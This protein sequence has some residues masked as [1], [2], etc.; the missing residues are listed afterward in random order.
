MKIPGQTILYFIIIFVG[1]SGFFF[2]L[3]LDKPVG[4][5]AFVVAAALGGFGV[6]YNVWNTKRSGKSL[7]CP[8]G[9]DCNAVVNSKYSK[10]LKIRIK[11]PHKF[12]QGTLGQQKRY[13]KLLFIGLFLLFWIDLPI[14][15]RF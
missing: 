15:F 14:F 4:F 12:V 5:Y 7:V 10:F 13:L 6:A 11:S 8:T 2:T 1:I 9:S 3:F